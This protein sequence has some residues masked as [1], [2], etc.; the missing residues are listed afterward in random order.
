MDEQGGAAAGTT[1]AALPADAAAAAGSG[2]APDA[3]TTEA[4]AAVMNGDKLSQWETYKIVNQLLD[5]ASKARSDEFVP[6]ARAVLLQNLKLEQRN[7]DAKA[8]MDEISKAANELGS[9]WPVAI[10]M[11]GYDVDKLEKILNMR[12]VS[13]ASRFSG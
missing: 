3:A 11:P 8:C 9:G 12:R 2:L 13:V 4:A 10:F 1:G 5:A 7:K 6:V